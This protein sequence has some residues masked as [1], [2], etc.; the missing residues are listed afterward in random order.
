[1]EKITQAAVT[2]AALVGVSA[3]GVSALPTSAASDN[4]ASESRPDTMHKK[5][6]LHETDAA[7]VG[8]SYISNDVIRSRATGRV[9][10]YDSGTS[11]G[12]PKQDRLVWQVAFALDGGIIVARLNVNFEEDQHRGRILSGTGRYREIEGTMTSR[13]KPNSDTLV[14]L[15]YT[16]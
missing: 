2:T 6:V 13:V 14:T 5:W 15:H 4:A 16:L 3:L 1:M 7:D 9:V 8:D 10:G 11:K 12:Y